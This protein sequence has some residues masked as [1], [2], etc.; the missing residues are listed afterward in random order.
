MPS[1]GAQTTV[2]KPP[3]GI[4]RDVHVTPSGEDAALSSLETAAKIEPFHAIPVQSPE[5]I[6]CGA[7]V[8]AS[9]EIATTVPL[10]VTA[11]NSGSEYVNPFTSVEL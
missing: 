11:T 3:A 1:S 9:V 4:V 7:Q 8:I 10:F 6:T 5:A 2:L